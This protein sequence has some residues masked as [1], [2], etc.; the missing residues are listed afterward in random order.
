MHILLMAMALI[1]AGQ[2]EQTK[3]AEKKPLTVV[4]KG[5]TAR[6][7]PQAGLDEYDMR[8]VRQLMRDNKSE[9]EA[10]STIPVS[11][12]TKRRT[13]PRYY[14]W[15]HHRQWFGEG[16]SKTHTI[17]L[18]ATKPFR[19]RLYVEDGIYSDAV[20]SFLP[21]GGNTQYVYPVVTKKQLKYWRDT[22]KK[23]RTAT[24]HGN[25]P[26]PLF[27]DANPGRNVPPNRRTITFNAARF[28]LKKPGD[29][30]EGVSGNCQVIVVANCR[31]LLV[32]ER[33]KNG[34]Q[35]KKPGRPR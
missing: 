28:K 14:M 35:P 30:I 11:S 25:G 17:R 23:A 3:P 16:N 24:L 7:S 21:D 27:G 33:P 12:G 9:I 8:I 32:I 6:S 29:L 20:A 18:A 2:A 31:W 5:G 13:G 34:R 26:L 1:V 22:R 10:Q 4:L 19:A 15:V